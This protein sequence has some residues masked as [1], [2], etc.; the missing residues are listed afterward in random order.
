MEAVYKTSREII[1]TVT[2]LIM[3]NFLLEDELL[4]G[5]SVFFM[6]MWYALI[7]Y[8]YQ[9]LYKIISPG[10]LYITFNMVLVYIILA[11]LITEEEINELNASG[12]YG[13][14]T[15][16]YYWLYF[17]CIAI[18]F[19]LITM[20]LCIAKTR[21]YFAVNK[22]NDVNVKDVMFGITLLIAIYVFSGFNNDFIYP[23]VIFSI[24]QAVWL[25]K[26]IYILLLGFVLILDGG[27]LIL[28][29]YNLIQVILP[30][31]LVFIYKHKQVKVSNGKRYLYFFMFIFIVGVYGTVSEIIKLNRL[32]MEYSL[33]DVLFSIDESFGFFTKQFYRVFAIWIKLG[34]YI[35]YH[36][37]NNGF[38]YGLSFIKGVSSFFGVDYISIP[39]LGAIYDKAVYAQTGSLVE[40]Y[41]NFGIV[42]A[43][44]YMMIIFG[45]MEKMLRN[46]VCNNNVENLM[47]LTIPFTK[48]LLDG[49]SLYSA[50]FIWLCCKVIFIGRKIEHYIMMG[51]RSNYAKW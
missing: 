32:G 31:L 51:K 11:S 14:W 4:R 12:L 46:L 38:F 3:I 20:Y 45:F 10:Y 43:V 18:S 21:T 36:V 26:Y 25:K 34:G 44:V 50:I 22:I 13:W 37:D 49:G 40:G 6:G 47:C 30:L 23:I 33:I 27:K 2:F 35:I 8:Q 19:F 1:V 24:V 15:N 5:F 39:E 7:S 42:G 17:N 29:R 48:I 16:D 28:S 9:R 41:A